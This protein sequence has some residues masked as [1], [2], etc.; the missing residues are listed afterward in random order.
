MFYVNMYVAT[1]KISL[2]AVIVILP[3]DSS[4]NMCEPECNIGQCCEEGK[5]M[6]LNTTSLEVKECKSKD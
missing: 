3:N 2:H 4:S 6:C 1:Y 5:C